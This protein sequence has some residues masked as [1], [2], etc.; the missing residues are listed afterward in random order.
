MNLKF[1][2]IFTPKVREGKGDFQ[3]FRLEQKRSQALIPLLLLAVRDQ[4][5]GDKRTQLTVRIFESLN[6]FPAV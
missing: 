1:N 3:F 5:G 6:F 4:L 2:F